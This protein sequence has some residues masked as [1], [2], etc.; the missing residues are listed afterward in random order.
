MNDY[1]RARLRL[2]VA[3]R[4]YRLSG[5]SRSRA[6]AGGRV[7]Q[8][9][10]DCGTTTFNRRARE[11]AEPRKTLRSLRPPRLNVDWRA[12]FALAPRL[13]AK[14]LQNLVEILSSLDVIGIELNRTLELDS[15]AIEV[16]AI[17]ER[18]GE[19][20]PRSHVTGSDVGRA[21]KGRQRVVDLPD[22][23]QRDPK[24]GFTADVGRP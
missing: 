5:G 4:V 6:G 8:V 24:V 15:R 3:R 20:A 16:A 21:S 2:S 17:E 10:R 23:D 7:R 14:R 1:R 22:R 9:R 13:R 18:H 11:H 19:I 12:G